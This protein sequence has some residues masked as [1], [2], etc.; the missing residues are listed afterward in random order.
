MADVAASV[1]LPDVRA[2]GERDIATLAQA[3]LSA[4]QEAIAPFI[5][6]AVVDRVVQENP[7][8]DFL[9]EAQDQV[10]VATLDGLAVG[11]GATEY[12]DD[13][14]SDLWIDPTHTGQGCGQALLAALMSRIAGRGFATARLEVMT[15]NRRAR[16]IYERFGFGVARRLRRYDPLLDLDIDKVAMFCPIRRPRQGAASLAGMR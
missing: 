16:R 9:V 14:I 5:P 4:W 3:G 6:P 11:F 2:M 8:L 12:G 1:A 10:L 13:Y 7:F 15:Q